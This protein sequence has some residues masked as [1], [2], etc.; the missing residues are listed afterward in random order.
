MTLW[1]FLEHNWLLVALACLVI[2]VLIYLET[3]LSTSHKTSLSVQDAT[4]RMKEKGSLIIDL[5]AA[6]D[7]TKGHIAGA[8]H[9]A[10]QSAAAFTTKFN[11]YKKHTVILICDSGTTSSQWVGKLK[12]QGFEQVHALSGGIQAWRKEQFPLVKAKSD[13]TK[14]RKPKKQES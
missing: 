6:D 14:K 9:F 5:R 13:M 4:L 1:Q 10:D 7:Y 2:I 3:R 11:K 12:K 8:K